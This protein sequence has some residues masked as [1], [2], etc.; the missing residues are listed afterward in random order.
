MPKSTSPSLDCQNKES[1][2]EKKFLP[3]I[4]CFRIPQAHFD[5]GRLSSISAQKN[6]EICEVVVYVLTLWW[7]EDF[8]IK[9]TASEIKVV[10][11]T[12][13]F[14]IQPGVHMLGLASDSKQGDNSHRIALMLFISSK[15]RKNQSGRGRILSLFLS[16]QQ[17]DVNF[18]IQNNIHYLPLSPTFNFFYRDIEW[19]ALRNEPMQLMNNHKPP[20]SPTHDL[21]LRW[22]FLFRQSFFTIVKYICFSAL[23]QKWVYIPARPKSH[24]SLLTKEICYQKQDIKCSRST[25]LVIGFWMNL[26]VFIHEWGVGSY[27]VSPHSKLFIICECFNIQPLYQTFGFCTIRCCSLKN[28]PT[29]HRD[30]QTCIKWQDII[31][32]L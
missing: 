11:L 8:Y 31:T 27:E 3:P 9:E 13:D 14:Q 30:Y 19:W 32:L 15:I 4:V 10:M 28:I 25:R 2:Q 29:L 26:S 12:L 7:S 1:W 21:K 20:P 17:D 23:F 24:A 16:H 6:D 18:H 5:T 22:Y